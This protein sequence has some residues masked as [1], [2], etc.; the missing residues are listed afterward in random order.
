M[1]S[2]IW[3]NVEEI[4]FENTFVRMLEHLP[5]EYMAGRKGEWGFSKF[6][7]LTCL[8][9]SIAKIGTYGGEKFAKFLCECFQR[10]GE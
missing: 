8:N 1:L 10:A 6:T 7:P 4:L 5:T 3:K 2:S 9:T